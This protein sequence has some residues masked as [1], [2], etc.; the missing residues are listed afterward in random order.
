M[1]TMF[2]A[3]ASLL[4]AGAA[5]AAEVQGPWIEARAGWDNLGSN[6]GLLY[7][8]AAGFDLS[9]SDAGF[10]GIQ[11]GIAGST[12]EECPVA[13]ACAGTG[14]DIEVLGRIGGVIA[15]KT[16]LYGLIGVANSRFTASVANLEFGEN[17]TGFR[18]GA[19]VERRI[20]SKT[21]GKLEYRF[22]AYGTRDIAGEP[23]EGGDRHQVSVSFGI[24]F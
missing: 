4:L 13:N 6:N 24:R 20:G 17:F 21:Y 3:A 7:G 2:A 8:A 16:A 23:V 14:R 15:D 9:V 19:G 1:K 11:A 5:Q 12:V 10:L 22:T 18:A